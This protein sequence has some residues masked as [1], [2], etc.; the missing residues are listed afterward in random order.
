MLANY[1]EH[2]QGGWDNCWFRSALDGLAFKRPDEIV[3]MI[4]EIEG[5]NFVVTFP[6]RAPRTVTA[7]REDDI[8]YAAMLE[9]AAD[10]ELGNAQS[11]RL[12]AYGEGIELLTGHSRTGYTNATGVG[13]APLT[14]LWSRR[15]WLVKRLADA[16]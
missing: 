10:E 15:D 13:F 1:Q 4:Q 5:G 8:T 7:T 3:Q 9:V 11:A 14:V 6:G 2:R 16:T 12:F